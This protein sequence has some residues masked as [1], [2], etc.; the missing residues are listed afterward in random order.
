M[1]SWKIRLGS[2]QA[3]VNIVYDQALLQIIADPPTHLEEDFST[4]A[5]GVGLLFHFLARPFAGHVND[6]W[7]VSS[8]LSAEYYIARLPAFYLLLRAR[9]PHGKR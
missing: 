2:G 1:R 9:T 7:L 8:Y 5:L 6:L 3:S 4:Y